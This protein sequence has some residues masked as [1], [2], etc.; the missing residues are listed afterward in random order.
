[1]VPTW[2]EVI[3]FEQ[4]TNELQVGVDVLVDVR[5]PLVTPM[6]PTEE[7]HCGLQ[8][9]RGPRAA[10]WLPGEKLTGHASHLEV[11]QCHL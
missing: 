10:E 4:R 8:Q 11:T 2:I 5:G 1:M 7:L 3:L 6:E 9:H